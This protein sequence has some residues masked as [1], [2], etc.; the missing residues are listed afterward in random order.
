MSVDMDDKRALCEPPPLPAE[1]AV[2]E[3]QE[4][5][6]D[7]VEKIRSEVET[8]AKT[9]DSLCKTLF[10]HEAERTQNLNTMAVLQ[11]EVNH[12]AAHV[13]AQHLEERFEGLRC[14]VYTE[15]HYLRSLLS[16]SPCSC[17]T[18]QASCSS[19]HPSDIQR[20]AAINH[21]SQEL[22]HSRRVLWEQ[23]A[24]LREEVHNIHGLLKKL[25]DETMR[26]LTEKYCKDMCL[27]RMIDSYQMKDDALKL[28]R[29][30][31][32]LRSNAR[33]DVSEL[34]NKLQTITISKGKAPNKTGRT[35]RIGQRVMP[36]N[37][38]SDEGQSGTCAKGMT[39]KIKEE[40]NVS[41]RK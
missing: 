14:E 19:T 41:A 25:R 9:I 6:R 36:A 37:S 39:P 29:P 20:Q 28:Q 24:E 33:S 22:Y 40:I 7:V 11:S 5:L 38:D 35:E 30:Q 12:L 16:H 1:V 32:M 26:R 27:E 17:P 10:M 2:G 34:Q 23:I 3:S 4:S 13:A 31:D 18:L 15:L 21:I 8:Q